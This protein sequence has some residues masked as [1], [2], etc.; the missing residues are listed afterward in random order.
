MLGDDAKKDVVLLQ[1]ENASGLATVSTDTT[2]I[3]TGDSVTAVGDAGGN[4]GSLT[5]APGQVTDPRQT[6]TVQDDLSGQDRKLARLIEVTSDVVPGDSGGAL[7]DADG[8]VVGMNVDASS[9]TTSETVDAFAIPIARVLRVVD[10]VEARAASSS[11][12]IGGTPFLGVQ[13]SDGSSTLTGVVDRS[14]AAG[15]GLAAGDTITELD[16]TSVATAGQLRAAVAARQNVGR[17]GADLTAGQAV[18]R[19]GDVMSPAR[20]DAIAATGAMPVPTA[21]AWRLRSGRSNGVNRTPA[22]LW[23]C[24]RAPAA[25]SST[26]SRNR[27]RAV[28]PPFSA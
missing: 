7:L 13:L 20:L 11:V 16:G 19:A 21:A 22:S 1:L 23:T 9:G 8:Q 28:S 17:R 24:T 18:V 2:G 26:L 10:R 12:V 6:I 15:L 14:P 4:G 5:A 25:A 3:G 27:S